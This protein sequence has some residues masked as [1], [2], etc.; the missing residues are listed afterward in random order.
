MKMHRLFGVLMVL[1]CL[2]AG[3]A[4]AAEIQLESG[5]GPGGLMANYTVNSGD[6][7]LG[8]NIA[9]FHRISINGSGNVELTL[10]EVTLLPGGSM[11]LMAK[12][13]GNTS[14]TSIT[15]KLQGDNHISVLGSYVPLTITGSGS[16]DCSQNT[17]HAS[18]MVAGDLTI[19]NGTI[20]AE[21]ATCG[22]ATEKGKVRI[23]GGSLT[24]FSHQ[25]EYDFGAVLCVPSL[26]HGPSIYGDYDQII[27]LGSGNW[28][29]E[30]GNDASSAQNVSN[31]SGEAYLH[32]EKLP[33]QNVL[34]ETGDS[35]NLPLW[36]SL[37]AVST[38]GMAMMLR[39]RK[40]A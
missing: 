7:I 33:E 17:E 40:E 31:Y 23:K 29:I 35:A 22:I 8:E 24:A 28:I 34:P 30:A 4:L 21:G 32:I 11:L 16:L 39:R 13:S 2:F 27:E 12:Q 18:L 19:E 25:K 20:V 6:V 5:E 1:V 38:I 9:G 37:I 26:G 10:K 3:S 14:V 36:I 15:L